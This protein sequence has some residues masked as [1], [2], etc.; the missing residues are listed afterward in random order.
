[1]H[2]IENLWTFVCV[3]KHQNRA[4]FDKVIANIKRYSFFWLTSYTCCIQFPMAEVSVDCKWGKTAA[5]LHTFHQPQQNTRHDN[6]VTLST[7]WL[8]QYP[9]KECSPVDKRPTKAEIHNTR[10]PQHTATATKTVCCS[11]VHVFYLQKMHTH[12]YKT[13]TM[14]SIS[15]QHRLR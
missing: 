7:T 13:C 8:P 4:L 6:F 2:V 15:L 10:P 12:N 3:S 1:M 9:V 14:F 5:V 11:H